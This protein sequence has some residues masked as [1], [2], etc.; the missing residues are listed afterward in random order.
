MPGQYFTSLL[1]LREVNYH[2]DLVKIHLTHYVSKK[3]NKFKSQN[4]GRCTGKLREDKLYSNF[5]DCVENLL[6]KQICNQTL[7]GTNF[8]SPYPTNCLP[9]LNRTN[10]SIKFSTAAEEYFL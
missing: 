10:S 9:Y 8:T 2:G 6:S 3:R 1:L 7:D 4:L 5:T